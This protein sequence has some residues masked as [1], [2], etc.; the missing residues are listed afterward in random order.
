MASV[1]FVTAIWIG[2]TV[3][4][5]D[6][7][8]LLTSQ[9]AFNRRRTIPPCPLNVARISGVFSMQSYKQTYWKFNNQFGHKPVFPFYI[10]MWKCNF[11]KNI[12][13]EV[14]HCEIIILQEMRNFKFPRQLIEYFLTPVF[15]LSPLAHD[16]PS[17]ED[18][19]KIRQNTK[20]K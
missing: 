8:V 9:F 6:F 10:Y 5:T 11:D 17:R 15:F 16:P 1:S 4:P 14:I 13:C 18:P 3:F 12:P 2:L 7:P 20:Q 19:V